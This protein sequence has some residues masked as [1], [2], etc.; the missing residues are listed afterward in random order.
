MV[1]LTLVFPEQT[2]EIGRLRSSDTVF[3]QICAD[4]ESLTALLPCDASDPTY[5]DLTDSLRGLEDEIRLYLASKSN[6]SEG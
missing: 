5:T 2:N 3:A 1:S 6:S 4:Y